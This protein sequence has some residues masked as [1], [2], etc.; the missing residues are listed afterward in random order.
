MASIF[1]LTDAEITKLAA[2]ASEAKK[3]AYCR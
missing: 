1:E 3:T 2:M